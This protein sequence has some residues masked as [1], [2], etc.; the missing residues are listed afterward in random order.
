[1]IKVL[2]SCQLTIA[3]TQICSKIIGERKQKGERKNDEVKLI[4]AANVFGKYFRS[5]LAYSQVCCYKST[6]ILNLFYTWLLGMYDDQNDFRPKTWDEKKISVPLV[7]FFPLQ[8]YISEQFQSRNT[9]RNT[10]SLFSSTPSACLSICFT[11]IF[12]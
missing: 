4:F 3:P 10:I 12:S 8:Q 1:M 5:L 11:P 9:M 2:Y 7:E 6:N